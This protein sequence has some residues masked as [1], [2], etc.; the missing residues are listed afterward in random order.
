M[1]GEIARDQPGRD[2]EA[3]TGEQGPRGG[4]AELR[5]L[6][7]V[8][9]S[10]PLSPIPTD[11]PAE[12]QVFAETLRVLFGALGVSLNRL[13]ALLHSDPGTVS[14]YLSGRR[15]PPPGFID[16]LC[17]AVY[18]AKGSLVTEQVRELVHQQ[19][20][21]ALQM[22]NP[23]RYEVQRLTDLLQAAAQEKRQYE[24]T[25][26]ALEE[27][28]ASRNDKI[29][30]LELEGRQLRSAWARTEEL[31]DEEKKHRERLQQAMDSLYTEVSALQA[32]LVSAQ[33]RAAAAEER[34]RELEARLDSAGALLPEEDRGTAAPGPARG[35]AGLPPRPQ[36]TAP[37]HGSASSSSAALRD[38]GIRGLEEAAQLIRAYEVQFIP[39]LLQT[40]EY[41]RAVILQ[42]APGLNPDEVERRLALRMDR[43]ELLTRGNPPRYWVI[44][45]EA[46]LRRPMGG[47]DVHVRQIER[48]IDLV[49]NPNVTIQVMPFRYGGHAADGGAFTIMRFSETDLPDVVCT[50]YLTGEHYIGEPGEVNRYAAVMERL[51]VAGTSPDRTREILSGMLKEI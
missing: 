41:A 11:V 14:R 24:I 28:I 19:F 22:H 2:P 31:L 45:D 49:G 23:A 42:S 25:V 32:R 51:S 34:C 40:A 47:R 3:G 17:K 46:A 38:R 1:S 5:A 44:M 6:A 37:S 10:Q 18:D 30:Q 16:G 13:A 36:G 9:A 15:I 33:R 4:L 50:E 29:Y 43:Q 27:A 21:V 7:R 35:A 12:I 8:S 48:L 20:L 39:A 26:A